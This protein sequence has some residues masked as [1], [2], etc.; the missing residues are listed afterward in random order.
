M[1]NKYLE[2]V[3]IEDNDKAETIQICKDFHTSAVDLADKYVFQFISKYI[4]KQKSSK[5]ICF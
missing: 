2:H 3:E 1:A 5:N 4:H